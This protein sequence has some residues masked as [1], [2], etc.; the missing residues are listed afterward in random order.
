MNL[1]SKDGKR[2]VTLE[3]GEISVLSK[4]LEI[5]RELAVLLPAKHDGKDSA[6]TACGS[7]GL[8]LV[9]MTNQEED[10]AEEEL[11]ATTKTTEK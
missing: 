3:K 7:I 1:K 6:A 2:S 10:E 11:A 8:V 4:S 5:C 9:A